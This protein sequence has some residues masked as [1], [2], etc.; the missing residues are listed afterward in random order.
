MSIEDLKREMLLPT[1]ET[2]LG[3]VMPVKGKPLLLLSLTEQEGIITL[4]TLRHQPEN[5]HWA[6]PTFDYA[7]NREDILARAGGGDFEM[8]HLSEGSIQGQLLPIDS[9]GAGRLVDDRFALMKLQHFAEKG[10]DLS[11][12]EG[13]EEDELVLGGYRL[14]EGVPFPDIDPTKEMPVT[15]R[16]HEG[17]REVLVDPPLRFTLALGEHMQEGPYRLPDLEKGRDILF[18][19]DGVVK[20]DI[21]REVEKQEQEQPLR[22]LWEEQG[23]AREEIDGMLADYYEAMEET[24]PRGQELLHIQYEAED[25]IQLNFYTREY[26]DN[27]PAMEMG[28]CRVILV[29]DDDGESRHG[30]RCQS[31]MLQAVPKDFAG[32]VEV[33]LVSRIE[34]IPPQVVEG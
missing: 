30:H 20:E 11:A 1:R 4:W 26:L 23:L 31:C 32:A 7:T 15:L 3:K 16:I 33:E 9:S 21:W 34:R 18:Y 27:A 2:L 28:G 22:Q 19:I 24:C 6:P 13:I 8:L 10:I 5:K 25:D 14:A 17:H 12:V 29:A